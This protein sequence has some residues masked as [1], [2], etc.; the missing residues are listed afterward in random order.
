[1]IRRL[2]FSG[3]GAGGGCV[4]SEYILGIPHKALH[5][6]Q[7]GPELIPVFSYQAH[8]QLHLVYFSHQRGLA[9]INCLH[10]SGKMIL[11]LDPRVRFLGLGR[12]VRDLAKVGLPA[13]GSRAGC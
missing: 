4:I 12:H 8:L 7:P 2:F 10:Q 1:M 5:L 11:I 9:G 13:T 6:C 3:E